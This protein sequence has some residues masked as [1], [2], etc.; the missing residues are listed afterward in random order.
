MEFYWLGIVLWLSCLKVAQSTKIRLLLL[1]K[2]SYETN[3][4]VMSRFIL[5]V[6]FKT[7]NFENWEI[8]FE[9]QNLDNLDQSYWRENTF[10]GFCKTLM[11]SHNKITMEGWNGTISIYGTYGNYDR[12]NLQRHSLISSRNLLLSGTWRNKIAWRRDEPKECL[13]L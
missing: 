10:Y 5:I 9:G 7:F 12:R 4:V 3:V 13:R 8:S 2:P 11:N 6:F 1:S